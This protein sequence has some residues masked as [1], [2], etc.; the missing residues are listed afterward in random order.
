MGF[1]ILFLN[2]I[3]GCHSA[4]TPPPRSNGHPLVLFPQREKAR[5]AAPWASERA[6]VASIGL[7]C[8]SAGQ[9]RFAALHGL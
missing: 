4:R 6:F 8:A 3:G 2:T 5:S 7:I 1:I 9:P